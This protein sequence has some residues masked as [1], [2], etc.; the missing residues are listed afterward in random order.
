MD[1]IYKEQVGLSNL[2]IANLIWNLNDVDFLEVFGTLENRLE[3]N[4]SIGSFI[5][6]CLKA[7]KK[8]K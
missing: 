5:D 1:E 3:K 7:A 4:L 6:V 8:E 2:Q